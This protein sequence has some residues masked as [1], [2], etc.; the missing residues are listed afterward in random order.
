MGGTIPRMHVD[1][2]TDAL[3]WLVERYPRTW[4]RL[5]D[6][7]TRLSSERLAGVVVDRP[8]YI[9]GLARSGSTILLELLSRHRDTATHRYR[10]FPLVPTPLAWNWFVDRAGA[11]ERAAQ[12]RA[13]RDRILVTSESPEAFEEVVWMAFFREL[14]DPSKCAVMNDGLRE[15]RFEAFY[16]DHIRKILVLRDAPRYLSKG[17]Y[18]VTRLKYLSRICPGARFVVPI[19][20]PV[21]HVASLMKQHALF[22]RAGLADRRVRRHLR[23]SGHFEFGA[24]RLPVQVGGRQAVKEVQELWRSGAEAEAWAAQWSNVYGHVASSLRD[25]PELAASVR[26]VRFEDLCSDPA[27]TITTVLDHCEL[28]INDLPETARTM[29]SRPT[30]YEPEFTESERRAIAARTAAVAAGFGYSS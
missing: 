9:A 6:W 30:Y 11:G 3:G 21:W 12:E 19:R 14:H 16:R 23:R 2:L 10:D 1:P 4:I 29:V 20:E 7:E 8:I 5:G 15:P 13:H 22:L 27:G 25:D 17:N 24:D 26:V 28:A 18:N